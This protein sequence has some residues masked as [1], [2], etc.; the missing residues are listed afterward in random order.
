MAKERRSSFLGHAATYAFANFAR[1]I[2]GFAMLP[3]YTRFLSPADYGVIGLLTIALAIFEPLFGARLSMALPK[4]YFEVLEPRDRRAVIWAAL[5]VTGAASLACVVLLVLFRSIGAEILFGDQKYAVALGLFS[6]N[7]LTRPLE[8]TGFMYLRMHEQS[9]MVLAVSMLKLLLQIGLN[10]LLVVFLRAGVVGAITSGVIASTLVG[11]ALTVYVGTKEPFA[12]SPAIARKMVLFSWPL[13]LS[14]IAGL[15]VGSSGGMYLRALGTL[16]DVGRLELALKFATVVTMLI[17]MP[18]SQ[19]WAPL[20][21]RYY[22]AHDGRQK[23]QAA[24][25][26]I[27]ALLF[28]AGLGVSVFAR[29]LI[30]VMATPGF[31]SAAGAIPI[32]TLGFIFNQLRAF[33]NFSFLVT[34]NTKLSSATQYLMAVVI[35]GAYLTLIPKYGIIGAA[36]GQCLA[37][38]AGFIF[39]NAMSR[40]YYDPGIK[41]AWLGVCLA[42]CVGAYCIAS[43]VLGTSFTMWN[44]AI[45]SAVY[46]VAVAVILG[47][48]I[49]HLERLD[50]GIL[51]RLPAPF[52]ELFEM[53]G[54]GRR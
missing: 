29:P 48:S 30:R 32:L 11:G 43:A 17:W 1:R 37:F 44:V 7:L 2:V 4:F 39:A 24:F 6:A 10:V 42:I 47:L 19:Q 51:D 28:C 5:G 46:V 23:F 16:D 12:F 34:D 18:F 36:L 20:S 9:K 49:R 33:F 35:T 38:S 26:A 22:R 27:T 52:R 31:Y 15:Y 40:R 25:I 45:S 54:R 3:I 14:G 8:D 50:F 53:C 21:Y 41:T 13:W